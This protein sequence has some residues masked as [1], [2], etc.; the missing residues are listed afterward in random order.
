MILAASIAV[1]LLVAGLLFQ[2]FFGDW[3]GFKECVRYYLTPD[4][5]SMFRGEWGEDGW[6]EMKLGVY[7]ALCVGSGTFVFFKL[8][9]L[10]G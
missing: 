7:V 2:A 5:I 3:D 10:F 8:T 9:Q 6:A 4:I 1:G